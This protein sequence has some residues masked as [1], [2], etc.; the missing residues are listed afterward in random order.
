VTPNLNSQVS[1]NVLPPPIPPPIIII[2]VLILVLT[3]QQR[4]ILSVPQILLQPAIA[5]RIHIPLSTDKAEQ[6]REQDEGMRGGPYDERKPD[7]EVV[8]VE[9][10]R[11]ELV[12]GGW[13][14]MLIANRDENSKN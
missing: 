5:L 1:V 10:L 8:D 9:N 11:G 4:R 6:Y 12:D 13:C 3:T 2:L 14:F 7:A